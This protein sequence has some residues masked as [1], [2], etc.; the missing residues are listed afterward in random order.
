[1]PMDRSRYPQNWTEIATRVKD[2]AGWTCRTCGR[3]CRR[4]GE[5]FD[6]HRRT[7]TVHHIDGDPAN[8][9]PENLIAVCAPCHLQLDAAHH[10]AHARE[11]RR[12]ARSPLDQPLPEGST[13]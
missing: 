12:H 10:A 2:D 1:M 6:T 3:I 4:P 13:P 11:T 9:N 5:K 7:L 8:S